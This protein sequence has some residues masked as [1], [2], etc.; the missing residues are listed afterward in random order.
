VV[1]TGSIYA[2]KQRKISPQQGIK[3]RFL[4]RP[5]GGLAIVLTELTVTPTKTLYL[6]EQNLKIMNGLGWLKL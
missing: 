3:I 1:P 4:F 6:T 2:A 5:D